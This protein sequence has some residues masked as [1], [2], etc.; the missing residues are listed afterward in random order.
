[1]LLCL[2]GAHYELHLRSVRLTVQAARQLSAGRRKGAAQRPTIQRGRAYTHRWQATT[3]AID[4]ASRAVVAE[5]QNGC[6]A[7]RGIALDEERGFLFASC[8]EG[9]TSVLDVNNGGQMLSTLARGSGFDVMGYA[10]KTG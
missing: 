2:H 9:T 1:V 6:A 3:V 5:W 4:L 10:P 7:S 8:L